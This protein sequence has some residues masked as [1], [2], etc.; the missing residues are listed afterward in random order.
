MWVR[1]PD[2]FRPGPVWARW[3]GRHDVDLALERQ[4]GPVQLPLTFVVAADTHLGIAEPNLG[5]ADL[6]R[7]VREATSLEPAPAFF[8]ILGDVTQGGRPEEFQV[9]DQ[10]L[11]GLEVP[12]IPVPGNHDWYD[13]GDAWHDHYGPDNYSF[14]LAGVHFVVWNMAL[15]PDELR[16]Y[17]SAELARVPATMPIVALTHEPPFGPTID[18]LRALGVDY[19]LTGHTHS[20]RV[21]DH[22]GMIELNTEPFLMGGLDFTPAGYRVVT[23][24]GSHLTS[25]HRTVVDQPFLALVAPRST[26]CAPTT[27]GELL[28]AAE[29]SASAGS[30]TARLDCGPRFELH[31]SGGWTWHAPLPRIDA[32]DHQLVLEARAPGGV[33]VTLAKTLHAC[34]R[35]PIPIA[36]GAGWPQVAGG[37]MHTGSVRHAIEPPLESRWVTAV[38]NHVVTAAP[39]IAGSTVFVATTD[40]ADGNRGG[41]VALELATGAVRWR[42]A[43]ARPLRGG[44]A[45]APGPPGAPGAPPTAGTAGTAGT[46]I[47]TQIDGEVLAFDAVSGAVRWRHA[48]STGFEPQAG[49]VFSP[50]TVAGNAVFVGHQ[51]AAS[52]LD[53]ASGHA[54]WTNDPVPDG[55]NSQSAAAIAVGHGLAVG[56]FHRE[57][58]GV[59]AWDARSGAPRWRHEGDDTVAINAAPVIGDD[60]IYLVSGTTDVLALDFAGKVR[61]RTK[62][63]AQGFAWGQAVVGT[64]ALA[65][66]TLVVPTMYGTLAGLDAR[67]GALRWRYLARPGPLRGTHYRGAGMP[68]FVASPVISGHLV[69][70]ADTSGLLSALDLRTGFVV[71]CTD[72]PSPVMAGLAASGDW[73]VIASYDGTV[74]AMA[75]RFD[76]PAVA[77]PPPACATG[78]RA[79]GCC[80]TS[81]GGQAP[82]W[83]ALALA[84]LVL[85]RRRRPT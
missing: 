31:R 20:N 70:V 57:L 41:V 63:D 53:A 83:F 48:M 39:I 1:V 46:V 28:V 85:R 36:P 23:I 19:V 65:G 68:A 55:R 37:A 76:P 81:G 75:P 9:A 26:D 74:R 52:R 22:G 59:V 66:D 69:W 18:L 5:A 33:H 45:F 32:G 62:I 71:W 84:T 42:A 12:W 73:L 61:W 67:T 80:N 64:P 34:V 17:L 10:G 82:G 16:A 25:Y 4:P 11:A 21:V 54:L 13:G 60:A 50:P 3:D 58:G 30:V 43:T 6:A 51:R 78:R 8:T 35:Y 29:L 56:V 15:S 27:G 24:D 40:L 72:L 77:S 14:D 7:A 79:A 44:L 47:T 49:A 2:G 38:G